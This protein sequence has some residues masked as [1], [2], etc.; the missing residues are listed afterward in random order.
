MVRQIDRLGYSWLTVM[1][2]PK[3]GKALSNCIRMKLTES[4]WKHG[5]LKSDGTELLGLKRPA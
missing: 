5:V 2:L 3:L 1:Q 4:N